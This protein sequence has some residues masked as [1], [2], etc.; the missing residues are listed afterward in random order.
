MQDDD[1]RGRLRRMIRMFLLMMFS[2]LLITFHARYMAS[3]IQ[4][5]VARDERGA[6]HRLLNGGRPLY[7]ARYD[8]VSEFQGSVAAAEKDGCAFHIRYNG[9]RLY[10]ECYEW[11]GF[12]SEGYAI[13]RRG[14]SEFHIN[15]NG[16]PAY[17]ERFRLVDPFFRGSAWGYYPDGTKVRMFLDG[18]GRVE[19]P[20]ER[21]PD[22]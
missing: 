13:A 3:E 11:V 6:Y 17:E 20:R 14:G 10:G 18:K 9:A 15:Y 4:A 12:F 19:I 21:V 2:M 22:R 16:T 1:L 7:E 8:R 5:E